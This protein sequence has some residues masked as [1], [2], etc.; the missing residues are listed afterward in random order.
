[1]TIFCST[2]LPVTPTDLVWVQ[3][4]FI[5]DIVLTSAAIELARQQFPTVRQHIITT[6]V[7]AQ[8]MRACRNLDSVTV[9][10]KR[11][12]GALVNWYRTASQL[13]R[14]LADPSRAVT[15]QLHRSFRSSMLARFL[16]LPTVTYR[17]TTAG[18][19]AAR[20][21]D[22]VAVLHEAARVALPLE[23]L[24]VAREAIV[25]ARPKLGVVADAEESSEVM[26]SFASFGG[27][28]IGVAAGSVWGT[29]RWP[30]KSYAE[31]VDGLLAD[32]G[33]AVVLLGSQDEMPIASAI[34]GMVGHR[35]RLWNLAGATSIVEMN[36]LIAG[37]DLLIAND[38]SPVHFASAHN[39]PT[40]AIF[41]ATIPQMGFA[42]LAE[43]SR[44]AGVDID[45]RPCSDHG[46]QKCPLGHFRC[47][48]TLSPGAVLAACKDMLREQN[49]EVGH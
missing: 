16:R 33:N 22:R 12:G 34:A 10:E 41:G 49:A 42:P 37:L 13:R 27:K 17:E 6:R 2:K 5:G 46:P 45:C 26:R 39:V 11:A 1:M 23:A 38:S 8:V 28:K 21:V 35:E 24:G 18:C 25:A 7:G 3:T 40:L 30:V 9:F 44:V 47:M 48:L 43:H 14:A 32:A 36:N 15:L 31:V 20:R 29:K 19:H 4:G